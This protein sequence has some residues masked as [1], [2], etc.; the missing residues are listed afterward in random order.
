MLSFLH[1]RIITLVVKVCLR[2]CYPIGDYH[3]VIICQ[4]HT[5]GSQEWIG[6]D[7]E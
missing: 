2:I 1:Q 5:K 4:K 3:N 6:A 7:S